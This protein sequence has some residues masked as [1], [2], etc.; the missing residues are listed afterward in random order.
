M[1]VRPAIVKTRRA[2]VEPLNDLTCEHLARIGPT[3]PATP[4]SFRG[5]TTAAIST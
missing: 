2:H 1:S 4:R 5:P 3:G